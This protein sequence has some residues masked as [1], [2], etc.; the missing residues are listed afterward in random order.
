MVLT[1]NLS[2]QVIGYSSLAKKASQSEI[3][4]FRAGE[5]DGENGNTRL[6]SE[7]VRVRV[8]IHAR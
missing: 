6:K 3:E 4:S 8:C 1:R 2:S 7:I 5:V